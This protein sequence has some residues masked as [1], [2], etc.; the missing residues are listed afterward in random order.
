M[1][2]DLGLDRQSGAPTRAACGG[3]IMHE[4][5]VREFSLAGRVAVV[6]GAASG[7]GRETARVLAQAGARLVLVDV[8]EAGLGE[9]AS[10]VEAVGS[11]A[12]T[13]RL[14]VS[15]R[16]AV[17]ALADEVALILGGLDVWVNAAGIL[18]TG[19]ISEIPE[20]QLDRLIAINMKGTYWGC[21]AAGRV[22][23]AQGRGAIVNIS[24]AGAESGALGNSAYGMTKAAVQAATRS[25]ATEFGALGVRVN[26]VA[27]GWTVTPM[28]SFRF[29]NEAGEIDPATREAAL[30]R[31]AKISPLGLIGQP[32]DIAL[33]VLYL[34]SDASR[35]VTGQV[36]RPN[37]GSNMP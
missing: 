30:Q 9:T 11:P 6:T 2:S 23:G 36:L 10:L 14:D 37:G 33:A 26:V 5:L 24:S 29:R 17:E 18:W 3:N 31:F 19:S 28:T 22:M 7:I 32:R 15:D 8:N 34:A 27:P 13:R 20:A 25:A 16:E 12:T 1:E 35:F 4:D 21:A